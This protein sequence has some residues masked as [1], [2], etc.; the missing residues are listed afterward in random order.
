M[1]Y[2]FHEYANLFPLMNT[3]QLARLIESLRKGF[4]PNHPIDLYQGKILDGRN[5]Y[6]A[7]Q[8]AHIEPI[9]STFTGSDDE[10]LELVRR[11]NF[12]RNH[13]NEAQRAMVGAKL[14][15]LFEEQAKKRQIE[16]AKKSGNTAFVRAF[17]QLDDSNK[18]CVTETKKVVANLPEPY[19]AGR[20]R[21]KAAEVA[22]VSGRSIS[23]ASK[24]IKNGAPELVQAVE[25]GQIAVSTAA[26]IAQ[27][28]KAEQKRVVESGDKK[29]IT[30][31]AKDVKAL[32]NQVVHESV[33]TPYITLDEWHLLDAGEQASLLTG[34]NGQKTFNRQAKD[35]RENP[36]AVDEEQPLGNIEWS[37]WSWNPVS[38]C[39]HDCPYCYARDIAARFYEQG[40]VP[41][42]YPDRL[43]APRNTK[44]PKGADQ[45]ISLKNVFTCSMADLFGRWVPAEWIEAVLEQVRNNPQWNFLFLTKFPKRLAEFKFPD[46]AWLGTTVDCQIRVKAAEDAFRKMREEGSGGV[47]WLS[48]EP[49]IEPLQFSSLEMFDWVVIGGSS[50]S[51]QTPAWHPPRA[52]VNALEA[53]AQHAGCKVYEKTNLLS[54]IRQ[55][56]GFEEPEITQAPAEFHYLGNRSV[57]PDGAQIVRDYIAQRY[58]AVQS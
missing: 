26:T 57:E 47:W 2:E 40:F 45:D 4:D 44:V 43:D 13:Y 37:Q 18:D 25:Q 12:D 55:Y 20:S 7:C 41:T 38:G 32:R 29:T 1:N 23:D 19:D 5:R 16:A 49:L 3:E 51:S 54:R 48:V 10:A 31:A 33:K 39:K 50:P 21:D 24:V 30:Q 53:Q 56:P 15:A 46:N 36:D 52:W 17:E 22:N 35:K 11:E 34:L 27:L 58:Q 28:P 8:Q 14:K 6:L 42:L 9:F